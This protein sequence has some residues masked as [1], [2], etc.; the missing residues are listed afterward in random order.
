MPNQRGGDREPVDFYD[1]RDD[2]FV[3]VRRLRV[4]GRR[5]MIPFRNAADVQNFPAILHQVFDDVIDRLRQNVSLHDLLGLEI[6][7]PALGHPILVPFRAA[8]NLTADQVFSLIERVTQSKRAL[9]FDQYITIRAVIVQN[10][11][12]GA[13][14][15][16]T[17][18]ANI[19][20]WAESHCGK[21]GSLIR[22]C[23]FT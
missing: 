1:I 23:F 3:R 11:T 6:N 20:E 15:R 16:R 2:G 7:H 18:V 22:V 17:D 8:G 19:D 10:P 13:R 4:L 21:A 14:K 5:F 9:A 12:G